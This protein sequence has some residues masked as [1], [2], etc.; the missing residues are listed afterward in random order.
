MSPLNSYPVGEEKFYLM[1][2]D[3]NKLL[4]ARC[5]CSLALLVYFG[6]STY[7]EDLSVAPFY[8]LLDLDHRP[9]QWFHSNVGMLDKFYNLINI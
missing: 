9:T 6:F 7:I 8:T 4:E 2:G 3:K 1:T 5:L